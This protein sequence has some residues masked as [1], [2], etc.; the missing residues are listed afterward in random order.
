MR[1][2]S[3]TVIACWRR[4]RRFQPGA[5][6]SSAAGGA[7]ARR[8]FLCSRASLTRRS[9]AG[10]NR[11]ITDAARGVSTRS[12]R[13][14]QFAL[15]ISI[16]LAFEEGCRL[17]SAQASADAIITLPDVQNGALRAPAIPV[18][19]KALLISSL[20]TISAS[21]SG[22]TQ[23]AIHRR[24]GVRCRQNVGMIEHCSRRMCRSISMCRCAA[25][26]A[27]HRRQQRHYARYQRQPEPRR[28]SYADS[29]TARGTSIC[30]MCGSPWL[31]RAAT[32]ERDRALTVKFRRS[33]PPVP[34]VTFVFLC[35]VPVS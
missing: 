7:D 32:G 16:V 3:R 25:I 31:R 26:S 21:D 9:R 4:C 22:F 6:I 28:Q 15:A 35:D 18:N 14:H 34:G 19:H 12:R 2:N 24:S 23:S 20:A 29:I 8:A 27:G 13:H 5:S 33:L 17:P 30:R 11:M 10:H 1:A